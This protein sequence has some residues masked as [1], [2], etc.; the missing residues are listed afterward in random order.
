MTDIVSSPNSPWIG[1]DG[2]WRD[3]KLS[4]GLVHGVTTKPLGDMLFA[5]A[6]AAALDK[7]GLAGWP[8]FLLKQVHGTGIVSVTPSTPAEPW[9]QGDGL[10]TNAPGLCLG[11][12]VADCLPLFLWAP[13]AR[14]AGVFHAGWR[15]IAAGMPR[16]AVSAMV[17]LYGAR[18]GELEASLGPRIGPCCCR[19]GPETAAQ[20]RSSSV[21][22]RQG[23]PHLDL[24]AEVSAQLLESGVFAGSIADCGA[25]TS[26]GECFFS[27]R[28]DRAAGRMMA[29]LCLP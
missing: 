9:P 19:V 24:A 4:E 20:F 2:I 14:A 29:F 21:A 6:R 18:P 13:S 8:L 26:C 1:S 10:T 27:Y 25:C 11:V 5:A 23:Q 7:V 28:R 15:G 22:Q 17:G 3:E 16:E 12:F